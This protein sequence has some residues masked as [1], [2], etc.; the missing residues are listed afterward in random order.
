MN[1][2]I[3]T[4]QITEMKWTNSQE[5]RNCQTDSI[6]NNLNR[7]IISKE[8]EVLNLKL[9][10]KKNSGPRGFTGEFYQAYKKLVPILHKL[11]Q[12]IE[13]GTSLNSLY[14]TSIISKPKT[15]Q[16]KKTIYQDLLWIQMQRFSLNSSK[17]NPVAHKRHS[18]VR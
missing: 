14:E 18:M 13:K 1:N 2:C 3:P 4:H 10:T 7:T 9:L 8:I 16:K 11:F 17:P 12:K 5:D 15:L 6:W